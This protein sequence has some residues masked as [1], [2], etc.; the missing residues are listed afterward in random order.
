MGNESFDIAHHLHQERQ[1]QVGNNLQPH[2]ITDFFSGR[3]INFSIFYDL[4]MRGAEG[5]VCWYVRFP[6]FEDYR[7]FVQNTVETE[8]YNEIREGVT[9]VQPLDD[10]MEYGIFMRM[11]NWDHWDDVRPMFNDIM[12]HMRD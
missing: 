1:H 6:S 11:H 3:G 5:E 7:N 9:N 4:D 8:W 12:H 10:G 2:N